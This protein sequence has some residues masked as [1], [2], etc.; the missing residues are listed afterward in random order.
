MS[1]EKK[2][3]LECKALRAKSRGMKEELDGGV[4]EYGSIEV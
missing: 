1:N 4:G 3:I 2:K